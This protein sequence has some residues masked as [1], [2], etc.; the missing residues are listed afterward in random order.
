[1]FSSKQEQ[2]VN[3]IGVIESALTGQDIIAIMQLPCS[4]APLE[5]IQN[6]NAIP[7]TI[8]LASL[9]IGVKEN[10]EGDGSNYHD[11]INILLI[12]YVPFH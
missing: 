11:E 5:A 1:M 3:H 4:Y 10:S 9:E 6:D 12:R 8:D 2:S 7:A